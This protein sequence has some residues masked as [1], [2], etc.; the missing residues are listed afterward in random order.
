MDKTGLIGAHP[1]FAIF[2]VIAKRGISPLCQVL[3]ASAIDNVE[4]IAMQAELLRNDEQL[5]QIAVP[6]KNQDLAKQAAVRIRTAELVAGVQMTLHW[7]TKPPAF[8]R[9]AGVMQTRGRF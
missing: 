9:K 4:P 6:F 1:G 7:G 2:E 3:A 8:I 5:I